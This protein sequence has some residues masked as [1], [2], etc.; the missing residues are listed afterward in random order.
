MFGKFSNFLH[1]IIKTFK[2]LSTKLSV[3]TNKIIMDEI[4]SSYRLSKNISAT[5]NG[6]KS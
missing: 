2:K 1:K 3:N 6:G 5:E 4:I